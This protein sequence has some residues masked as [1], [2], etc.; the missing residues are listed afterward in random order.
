MNATA[1]S[2]ANWQFTAC[3]Y[4]ISWEDQAENE[5]RVLR[6]VDEGAFPNPS[7]L[8]LPEMYGSGFSMDVAKIAEGQERSGEQFLQRLARKTTS[9]V[10][11][12]VV[13]QGENGSGKNELV[14]INPEGSIC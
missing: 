14:A 8:V 6:L 1:P 9:W 7:L 12:G 13:T 2:R 4:D 3:Q 10:F 5:A 11:G